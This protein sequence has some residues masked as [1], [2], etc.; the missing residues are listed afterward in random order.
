MRCMMQ[1]GRF[2]PCA[3]PAWRV[4]TA[5]S[6]G[7][8]TSSESGGRRSSSATRST[9]S[10]RFEEFQ[11]SP[12]SPGNV[13]AVRLERLVDAGIMERRRYEEHPP[14]DEYVLTEKGRDLFPVIGALL[15][16]G[17]RWTAGEAGP[18]L[19]LMH[20]RVAGRDAAGRRAI[21]AARRSTSTQHPAGSRTR[22]RAGRASSRR[23]RRPGTGRARIDDR[24]HHARRGG[25]SSESCCQMRRHGVRLTGIHRLRPSIPRSEGPSEALAAL[26]SARVR[27]I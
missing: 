6:P 14:R 22:G 27:Y 10:R 18:P 13:L 9:A 21:S 17:D 1:R 5:P 20:G 12:A 23:R 16:W 25:H 3:E 7:P 24:W 2:A 8:S 26:T 11:R 15:A 19:L 4:S